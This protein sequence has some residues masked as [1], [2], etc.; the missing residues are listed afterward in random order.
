MLKRRS[1]FEDEVMKEV[2]ET[3]YYYLDKATAENPGIKTVQVTGISEHCILI[4]G[5]RKIIDSDFRTYHP[6][7]EGVIQEA[8][9]YVNYQIPEYKRMLG[10]F[11]K[12][13]KEAEDLSKE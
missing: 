3:T 9:E 2:P 4:N 5:K 10:I 12:I 8:L 1:R 11:E 6:S 13:E 7:K